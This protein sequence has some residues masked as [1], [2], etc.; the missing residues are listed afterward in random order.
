MSP[1]FRD[2]MEKN[3]TNTAPKPNNNKGQDNQDGGE[4]SKLNHLTTYY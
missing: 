1:E 2:E 3:V 4:V